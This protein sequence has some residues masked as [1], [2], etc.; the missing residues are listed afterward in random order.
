M[1]VELRLHPFLKFQ[2][3]VEAD[4]IPLGGATGP[5]PIQA[6]PMPVL[7]SKPYNSELK[8]PIQHHFTM[9]KPGKARTSTFKVFIKSSG[10]PI[11]VRSVP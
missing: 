3:Q 7:P 9:T 6:S 11:T 2:A 4:P 10:T 1:T 8:T 5:S